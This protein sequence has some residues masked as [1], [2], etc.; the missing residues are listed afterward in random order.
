MS[1]PSGDSLA[2]FVNECS[3]EVVKFL[4]KNTAVASLD[5]PFCSAK[6]QQL[7]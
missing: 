3:A 5:R 7:V 1:E 2:P 4:L 6:V